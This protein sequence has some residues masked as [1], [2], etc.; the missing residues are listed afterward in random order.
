MEDAPSF[1]KVSETRIWLSSLASKETAK[2]SSK[3]RCS[4]WP[5]EAPR[6]IAAYLQVIVTSLSLVVWESGPTRGF[7]C[8][9]GG[10]GL[11]KNAPIAVLRGGARAERV[12]VAAAT[13]MA[14]PK[15]IR[16][17]RS[18]W[19]RGIIITGWICGG[20]QHLRQREAIVDAGCVS[21]S[22]PILF[23]TIP[24]VSIS[25]RWFPTVNT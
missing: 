11:K 13:K 17:K 12:P 25:A 24:P 6:G 14:A 23:D 4:D 20:S 5:F 18:A 1:V 7:A 9:E 22:A 3:R 15:P 19:V 10:A 8:S 16:A 21:P 2:R